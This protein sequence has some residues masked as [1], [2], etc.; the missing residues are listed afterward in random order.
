MNKMVEKDLG[1]KCK[2]EEGFESFEKCKKECPYHEG[3]KLYSFGVIILEPS[4]EIP[5]HFADPVNLEGVY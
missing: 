2:N 4:K 3:C 5:E 1:Y